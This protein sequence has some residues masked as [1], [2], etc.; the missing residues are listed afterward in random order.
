MKSILLLQAVEALQSSLLFTFPIHCNNEAPWSAQPHLCFHPTST[1]PTLLFPFPKPIFP[2][3]SASLTFSDLLPSSF[4]GAPSKC[5]SDYPVSFLSQLGMILLTCVFAYS[6]LGPPDVSK[7][8]AGTLSTLRNTGSPA[9]RSLLEHIVFGY[10]AEPFGIANIW[11]C[12]TYKN[13]SRKSFNT[14]NICWMK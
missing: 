11:P 13:G 3:C 5:Q 2:W 8:R 6:C 9:P 4:H 1:S 7:I 14:M 10:L 12:L